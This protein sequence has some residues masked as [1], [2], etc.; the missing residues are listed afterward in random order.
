MGVLAN[1]AQGGGQGHTDLP[2]L[3]RGAAL[4]VWTVS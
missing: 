2:S 3:A 4:R 1:I